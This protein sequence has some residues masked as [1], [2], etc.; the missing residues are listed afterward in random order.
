MTM[1]LVFWLMSGAVVVSE[2]DAEE[3]ARDLH[4]IRAWSRV[5]TL[6]R[7]GHLAFNGDPVIQTACIPKEPAELS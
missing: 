1:L 4:T 3:C 5:I 2:V 7:R 6:S